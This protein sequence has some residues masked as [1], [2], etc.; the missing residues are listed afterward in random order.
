LSSLL[1]LSFAFAAGRGESLA[2]GLGTRLLASAPRR[3]GG[4][5]AYNFETL[6]VSS[7]WDAH[8][9]HPGVFCVLRSAKYP[10]RLTLALN[11]GMLIFSKWR[12]YRIYKTI[13]FYFENF[14]EF[15]FAKR[16]ERG[17]VLTYPTPISCKIGLS[18]MSYR[19]TLS[20]HQLGKNDFT[21]PKR[22]L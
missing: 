14:D 3:L 5:L 8:G 2:W 6:G 16:F 22:I 10:C 18:V 11:I 21:N 7:A 19:Q 13:E 4:R 17:N 9:M 12:T 15:W 1:H 20:L